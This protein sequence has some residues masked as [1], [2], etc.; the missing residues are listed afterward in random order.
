MNCSRNS[1]L[2]YWCCSCSVPLWVCRSGSSTEAVA[3]GRGCFSTV[4]SDSSCGENHLIWVQDNNHDEDE[5]CPD[6][7]HVFLVAEGLPG[8]HGDPDGWPKPDCG[9]ASARGECPV[10]GHPADGAGAGWRERKTQPRTGCYCCNS[11][12]SGWF[13]IW[14]ISSWNVFFFTEDFSQRDHCQKCK[15]HFPELSSGKMCK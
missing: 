2:L 14:R 6:A 1:H 8:P 5:I 10:P 15:T 12:P 4:S 11:W 13:Y 9:A 3:V 7:A